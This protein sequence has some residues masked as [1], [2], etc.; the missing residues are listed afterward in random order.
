[1][2]QQAGFTI[3]ELI[4]VIALLGILGAVALPRFIN[5]TE[6]AHRA[7]VQ[8]T[9]GAF[10]SAVA[11]VR[12]Q[13]IV[14]NTSQ[15]NTLAI[16]GTNIIVNAQRAP[17]NTNGTAIT[18]ATAAPALSAVGCVN[19]WDAILQANA[20][21]VATGA[22]GATADYQAALNGDSCVY[23][24]QPDDNNGTDRTITYNTTNGEVTTAGL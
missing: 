6:D 17:V 22:T 15:G 21:S 8:G 2:K 16:D 12:A 1:M 18:N 23:T 19:V 13:A 4:V 7:S 14:E 24:Y 10:A 5:V 20:P 3:I 9:A 11:L